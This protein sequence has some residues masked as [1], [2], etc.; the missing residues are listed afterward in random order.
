[1]VNWITPKLG[2]MAYGEESEPGVVIIDV[3][4]LNDYGNDPLK[5]MPKI[6]LGDYVLR[7]SSERLAVR[8]FKGINRSNSIAAAIISYQKNISLESAVSMVK[9]MVPRAN[10][11]PQLL[12]A[13][14]AALILLKRNLGYS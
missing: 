10:P 12:K 1:M 3:R 6:M 7:N 4:D 5:I 11:N 9:I 2:T 13:V 8:C 14:E